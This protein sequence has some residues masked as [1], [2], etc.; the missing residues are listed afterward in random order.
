MRLVVFDDHASYWVALDLGEA[1]FVAIRHDHV[2]RPRAG[3][4]LE[5]RADGLW[6]ELVCEVPDEH[7]TFGLEAFGLRLDDRDEARTAD[8]GERVP[9]GF[10]L[11]WD[12]GHVIGEL[13]IGRS[14][15]PFD[16]SGHV[17][18]RS[19]TTT[20]GLADWADWLDVY[21]AEQRVP[22]GG[23]TT[24]TRY[25][26]TASSMQVLRAVPYAVCSV[27]SNVSKLGTGDVRDHRA[28]A[29]VRAWPDHRWCRRRGS[30]ARPSR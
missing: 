1:G 29:R 21:P 18:A 16:G 8:V 12:E 14:R 25:A 7:W 13:L 5:V 11:E 2:S 22:A 24:S 30:A 28:G 9:V 4:L 20:H 3:A 27:L 19:P 23:I 17:R 26:S 15:I 10:D 6:A